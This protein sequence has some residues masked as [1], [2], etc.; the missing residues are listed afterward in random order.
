[1]TK[2]YSLMVFENGFWTQQ[3]GDYDKETVI[4]ER[5]DYLDH[6]YRRKDLKIVVT[7]D[8]QKDIEAAVDDLNG[9]NVKAFQAKRK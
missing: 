3:F 9:L 5:D 6:Y 8:E 2:Y 4:Y 7:S 1:M